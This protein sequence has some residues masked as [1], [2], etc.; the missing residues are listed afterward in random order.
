MEHKRSLD[1]DDLDRPDWNSLLNNYSKHD[2]GEAYFKGRVE[3]IGLHVENWGIDKRHEDDHLIFDNKM[4]LRLWE[5]MDEQ[6]QKPSWPESTVPVETI[7]EQFDIGVDTI[8]REWQLRGVADVKTKASP[9]W[10]GKFNLRHLAHYAEWSSV[11]EVPVFIY[12][13]MVDGESETV[14][15]ED[16][17][18][19]VPSDWDW[20]LL[21]DHYDDD[22][23]TDLSY[24]E[25]KDTARECGIVHSTFRAPDGNLVVEISADERYN[26]D[27]LVEDVL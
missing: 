25:L 12:M 22:S 19:P 16:F 21:V 3:Q 7:T 2:I 6:E 27:Y 24:G 9:S 10:M 5:P 17:L 4:D 18:T 20:Q 13:T 23:F 15:D 11:Y 1:P 8:E 26:W 14:G